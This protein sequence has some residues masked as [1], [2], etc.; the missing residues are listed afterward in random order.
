MKEGNW[1]GERM[2]REMGRF[3][4]RCEERNKRGSESQ[5]NEWKTAASRGGSQWYLKDIPETW[6]VG[7]S[8]GINEVTLPLIHSSGDVEPERRNLL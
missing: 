6:K 2:G 4:I 8:S 1:V 7:G 5:D 3:G